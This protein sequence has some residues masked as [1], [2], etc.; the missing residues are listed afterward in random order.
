MWGFGLREL[1]W[2]DVSTNVEDSLVYWRAFIRDRCEVG[3]GDVGFLELWK[4]W[5]DWLHREEVV[6]GCKIEIKRSRQSFV[7]L[8]MHLGFARVHGAN[9]VRYARIRLI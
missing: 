9:P 7:V 4:A 3:R 5:D 8:L 2:A 1:G 6:K